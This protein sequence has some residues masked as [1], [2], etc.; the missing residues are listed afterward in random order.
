MRDLYFRVHGDYEAG[1]PVFYPREEC[2]W[3]ADVERESEIIRREF[4]DYHYRRGTTLKRAWVPDDVVIH[5]WRSINFVTCGRWYRENCA[6][7]PETVKVMRSIPGLTSAFINLLE[8]HSALPE[9]NGDTNATYRCHL[10]LIVPGD[11]DRCGIEVARQRVGWR[12]G[13]AFAFNEAFRHR[14]WNDTDRDRVILVFDVLKPQYRGRMRRICGGVLGAMV[15]IA[16]ETKV[17]PLRRLP[18]AARRI[19]HRLLA[20]AAS[21]ALVIQGAARDRQ[22]PDPSGSTMSAVARRVRRGS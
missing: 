20:T 13:Q 14:V 3:L 18:V 15:L 12:E 4:D 9:H 8:P 10:G 17:H 22:R 19:L 5:G 11:V 2:P 1:G 21:T 16:L 7:F 6:Q